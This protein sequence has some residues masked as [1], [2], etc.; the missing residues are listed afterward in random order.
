MFSYVASNQYNNHFKL[1]T[2]GSKSIHGVGSACYSESSTKIASLA[3]MASIFSAE[4]YAISLAITII[5]QISERDFVVF[6][7]SMS[8]L[9]TLSNCRSEGK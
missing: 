4:I 8:V 9:S 3:R 2:D 7:D 6:S 5:G 1:Y